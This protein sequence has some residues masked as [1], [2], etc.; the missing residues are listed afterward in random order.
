MRV[1]TTA[2]SVSPGTV[3][4]ATGA[5]PGLADLAL[6]VPASLVKGHVIATEPGV[7]YRLLPA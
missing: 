3:V 6:S 4:F 2:G 7:E 1:S 5:P